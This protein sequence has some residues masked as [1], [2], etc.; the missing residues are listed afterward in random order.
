MAQNPDLEKRATGFLWFLAHLYVHLQD[1]RSGRIKIFSLAI[2]ELLRT[3]VGRGLDSVTENLALARELLMLLKPALI[4]Q[5][6]DSLSVELTKL[7][8]QCEKL[9]AGGGMSLGCKKNLLLA[10]SA[11]RSILDGLKKATATSLSG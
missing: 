4:E 7:L 11:V 5:P 1:K 8:E 10:S 6:D 3:L 9:K 2:V